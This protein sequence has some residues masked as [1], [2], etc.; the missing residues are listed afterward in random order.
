GR[1]KLIEGPEE[2]TLELF[3]LESDPEERENLVDREAERVKQMR[4][5]IAAWRKAHT[6]EEKDVRLPTPEER[7]R[8]EAL[9]YTE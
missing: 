3:D 2:E 7:A 4:E 1:W 8:L 6:R 5:E 9:G